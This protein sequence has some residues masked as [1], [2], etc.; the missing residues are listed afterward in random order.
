MSLFKR[1]STLTKAALHEGLNKLENPVLLTGQYLRDLENEIA[2]A[3]RN[4]RDL[5]VTASVLERRKQEYTQLVEQSEAEAVQ[6]VE[7]G[8]EERARLALMAKLRYVEQL[9]EC[10]NSQAQ[11]QQSLAELEINIARAKEEREHLKAKRTELI[12]RAQQATETLSSAPRS[13]SVKGPNV[14]TASRGFERMEEKIFEWEALA[15]NSK[16]KFNSG[17]GVTSSIDPN[18]RSAVD[19]EIERI[20]NRKINIDKK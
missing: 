17:S 11:T 16:H 19:D 7:Q 20:R 12:A 3:E 13:S 5:K 10:I 1:I 4:E 6:S 8:N 2:T 18:I 14:G 15:E 9:E